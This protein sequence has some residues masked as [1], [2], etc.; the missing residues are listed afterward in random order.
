[1]CVRKYIV[2]LLILL[3][4]LA[5]WV[6]DWLVAL[7]ALPIQCSTFELSEIVN[8]FGMRLLVHSLPTEPTYT[9]NFFQTPAKPNAQ[10]PRTITF[11]QLYIMHASQNPLSLDHACSLTHSFSSSQLRATRHTQNILIPRPHHS[12]TL[13]Y[14]IQKRQ[15]IARLAPTRPLQRQKRK[16]P[17]HNRSRYE[18]NPRKPSF[19]FRIIKI[20]KW[21]IRARLI[22]PLSHTLQDL[23]ARG[24]RGDG[25]SEEFPVGFGQ[26]VAGV[27]GEAVALADG[28]VPI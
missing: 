14:D 2:Y 20:R 26:E 1:M 22:D 24:F 16:M 12:L 17:S 15:S 4:I 8:F 13:L 9:Y 27:E 5:N 23:G 7:S 3:Y 28:V 6:G 21:T 11:I 10:W 19:P 25:C 18:R